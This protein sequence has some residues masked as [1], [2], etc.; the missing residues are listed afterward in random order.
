MNI[1]QGFIQEQHRKCTWDE[2]F[3]CPFEGPYCEGCE[4]RP[5]DDDKP[6]GKNPPRPIQWE[7]DYGG[8]AP[9]CPTCGEM[10]YSLERCIFC[11]QKFIK[12]DRAMEWEKPLEVEHMDCIMC[13]GKGTVEYTRSRYNGHKNGKCT[14]CG[15]RFIE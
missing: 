4:H 14:A 7:R 10:P 9:L 5:A 1:F 13:G 6:N 3:D 15:M 12:D 8:I 2:S 11:G